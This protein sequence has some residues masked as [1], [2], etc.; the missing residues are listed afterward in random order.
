M[1]VLTNRIRC[2]LK[3]LEAKYGDVEWSE[4][5]PETRWALL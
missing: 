5:K 4:K 3:Y 2:S 1:E